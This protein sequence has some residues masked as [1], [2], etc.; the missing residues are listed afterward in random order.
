MSAEA[1]DK[2]RFM[3]RHLS[4]HPTLRTCSSD[5]ILTYD[6]LYSGQIGSMVRVNDRVFAVHPY[7]YNN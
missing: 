6:Q 3:M 7:D 1:N 5:T 2:K 4:Y